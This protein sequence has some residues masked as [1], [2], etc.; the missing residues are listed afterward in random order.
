[1][2]KKAAEKKFAGGE[3]KLQPL[4]DRVVERES[5]EMTTRGDCPA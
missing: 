5:A 4:G 1:M 2:A 3:L